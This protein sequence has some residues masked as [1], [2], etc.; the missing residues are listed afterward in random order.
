MND[1]YMKNSGAAKDLQNDLSGLFRK[2]TGVLEHY[3]TPMQM[4]DFYN[5][6]KINNGDARSVRDWIM[7]LMFISYA[8]DI[9]QTMREVDY[10]NYNSKEGFKPWP[11]KEIGFH[12]GFVEKLC[13]EIEECEIM[14]VRL[15]R[16][17]DYMLLRCA[18]LSS[19]KRATIEDFCQILLDI[20]K[21]DAFEWIKENIAESTSE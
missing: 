8:F 20:E 14:Q 5:N 4:K 13:K 16:K 9:R 11:Y 15:S 12:N 7:L 17:Y 21:K 10:M 6:A 2:G 1:L 19:L 3:L 18:L